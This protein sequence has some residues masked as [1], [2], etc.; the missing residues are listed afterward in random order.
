MNLPVIAEPPT[1]P[2]VL[3][4][5]SIFVF[6][7]LVPEP[8][9]KNWGEKP[10][11]A[12][13]VGMAWEFQ[14]SLMTHKK[15]LVIFCHGWCIMHYVGANK[16][17]ETGLIDDTWSFPKWSFDGLSNLPN[18][19]KSSSCS[20]NRSQK[21]R[22]NLQFTKGNLDMTIRQVKLIQMAPIYG[23]KIGLDACPMCFTF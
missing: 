3:V 23:Q 9:V 11:M 10:N 7:S 21:Y 19:A 18:P 13:Y 5:Y 14:R 4:F 20:K 12:V 8:Q 15:S 2:Y 6:G 16:L 17:L 1:L 22:I